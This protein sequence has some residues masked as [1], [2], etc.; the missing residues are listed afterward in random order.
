VHDCNPAEV[1]LTSP[2]FVE[3]NWCGLTYMA[4]IDFTLRRE[5][6]GFCTV[7]TD[8]GCG[9]I[10]KQRPLPG[11]PSPQHEG[12][13]DRLAFAWDAARHSEPMRYDFFDRHHR[14][15]L[16]LKTADEFFALEGILPATTQAGETANT[17]SCG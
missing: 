8:Y 16:N 7:D 5:G 1:S 11:T 13:R 9:V 17:L 2:D 6:L 15:L 14:E 4:F 3:G 12:A 10:Y